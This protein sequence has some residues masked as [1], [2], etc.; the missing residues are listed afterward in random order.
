MSEL[1]KCPFCGGEADVELMQGRYGQ[2]YN[3]HHESI[4]KCPAAYISM[5]NFATEAEAIAAWNTRAES[6]FVTGTTV[7][8]DGEPVTYAPTR[9]CKNVGYYIDSTRF[10]CSECGYN[11]WTKWAADGYDKVPNYCPNCGSKVIA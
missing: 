2:S 3:I 5:M 8:T 9:T 1:L 4:R 6:V 11:G 10:K 7:A